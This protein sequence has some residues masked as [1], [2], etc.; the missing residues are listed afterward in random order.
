[1]RGLYQL[2]LLTDPSIP[3]V[4]QRF[5]ELGEEVR[6]VQT[7]P[8]KMTVVD[9]VAAAFNMP[10]PVG[11]RRSVTT[12]VVRHPALAGTLRLAFEAVWSQGRS[13]SE[14]LS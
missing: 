13:L 10:D 1:M 7:V 5:A 11:G 4:L 3:P 2:D 6:L 14:A 8:M 9:G 12:L